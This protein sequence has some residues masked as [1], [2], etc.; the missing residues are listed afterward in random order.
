ME[1]L[2]LVVSVVAVVPILFFLTYRRNLREEREAKKEEREAQKKNF[3]IT[4]KRRVLY[5]RSD[6]VVGMDYRYLRSHLEWT[7]GRYEVFGQTRPYLGVKFERGLTDQE[8]DGL[9][10]K[11][12]FRFPPDLR[13]FLSLGLPVDTRLSKPPGRLSGWVNWR[14]ESE[15][16][17]RER[18]NH[19]YE[20]ICF[21]VNN[22]VWLKTWGGP[23]LALEDRVKRITELMNEAP[24][25]IPIY[26]HRYIPDRPHEEGNPI[27]SVTHT[28]IIHFGLDLENYL[29]KEFWYRF[30]ISFETVTQTSFLKK[31][32]KAIEFWAEIVEANSPQVL[33]YQKDGKTIYRHNWDGRLFPVGMI[34]TPKRLAAVEE[35]LVRLPPGAYDRLVAM[36][37]AFAWDLP[38]STSEA[39]RFSCSGGYIDVIF[40]GRELEDESRTFVI[41]TVAHQVAHVVLGHLQN[42]G[43]RDFIVDRI[44]ALAPELDPEALDLAEKWGFDEVRSDDYRKFLASR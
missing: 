3:R 15:A 4:G 16:E 25:L 27:F 20:A 42:L 13:A 18:L 6:A 35:V 12:D 23:P 1:W 17:I 29:E 11:F 40:L 37:D 32:A 19:P 28:D 33:P 34:Y 2:L 30:G 39:K 26:G 10:R 41:A 31:P 7:H 14:R 5:P 21:G 22:G 44:G 38:E 8:L 9:E 24:R 43:I 36:A